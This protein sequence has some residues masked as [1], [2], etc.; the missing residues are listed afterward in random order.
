MIYNRKRRHQ[1][2]GYLSP[3]QFKEKHIQKLV[4]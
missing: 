3:Y 1:L 2:L 4:A